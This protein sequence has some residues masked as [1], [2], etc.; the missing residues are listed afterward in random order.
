MN[1][2]MLNNSNNNMDS[3]LNESEIL[4]EDQRLN[5]SSLINKCIQKQAY[6]T[7]SSHQLDQGA[8]PALSQPCFPLL[9]NLGCRSWG[10]FSLFGCYGD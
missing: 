6:K 2:E 3:K 10:P 5:N 8:D 4:K 7:I 9:H 1:S